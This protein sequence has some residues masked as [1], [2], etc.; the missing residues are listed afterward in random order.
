MNDY[1]QLSFF[2]DAPKRKEYAL[3]ELLKI[4]VNEGFGSESK[5]Y[6]YRQRTI[7]DNFENFK[8]IF[9][10]RCVSE[11]RGH[12]Y[13][14]RFLPLWSFEQYSN[15]VKFLF[16]DRDDVKTTTDRLCRQ[17]YIE[18]QNDDFITQKDLKW[19][20]QSFNFCM[21]RD[22]YNDLRYKFRLELEE[23]EVIRD[24]KKFSELVKLHNVQISEYFA[25][26]RRKKQEEIEKAMRGCGL[27]AAEQ[28]RT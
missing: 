3:E 23:L 21:N 16:D 20:T 2:D 7:D 17:A 26:I 19:I 9:K 25:E 10:E 28:S 22:Y 18:S 24:K 11:Y 27:N 1:I 12:S 15:R 4:E 8:K 6:L 14:D 13:P 5:F